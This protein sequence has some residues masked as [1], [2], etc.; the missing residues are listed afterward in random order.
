M[1]P[2]GSDDDALTAAR[3]R[4]TAIGAGSLVIGVALLVSPEGSGRPS[5]WTSARRD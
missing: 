1:Q 3:R 2:A 5:G 4:A